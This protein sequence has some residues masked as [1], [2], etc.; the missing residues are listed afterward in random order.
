MVSPF[1]KEYKLSKLIKRGEASMP[2]EFLPLA[3]WIDKT[4][5]V[6]TLNIIYDY[7]D[8]G[9]SSPR[10]WIIF[11]YENDKEKFYTDNGLNL[12][13]N[14]QK[15]IAAGFKAV[16]SRLENK[17]AHGFVNL[18]NKK[19]PHYQADNLWVCFHVFEPYVKAEANEHVTEMQ[20]KQL[21]TEME[22]N[23]LWSIVKSF[24]T[25]VCFFYTDEQVRKNESN[26]IKEELSAKYLNILKHY[27]EFNYF[28]KDNFSII[29]DSKEN[30]DENYQSNWYY[31]FK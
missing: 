20:L 6:K 7:M 8:K 12:D 16:I 18:F 29:L 31:Y 15:E 1:E 9:I 28:N 21:E 25:A 17:R 27:D 22:N 11:E 5:D 23:E 19:A 3:D 14:K 24:S 13:R 30:F 26:G 2:E 10:L 4:Y